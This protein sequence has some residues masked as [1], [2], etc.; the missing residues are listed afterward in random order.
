MVWHSWIETGSKIRLLVGNNRYNASD[1]HQRSLYSHLVHNFA[2]MCNH[3]SVLPV[4]KCKD[5]LYCPIKTLAKTFFTT[6]SPVAM[7][8]FCAVHH[9]AQYGQFTTKNYIN[10]HSY[11]FSFCSCAEKVF[12]VK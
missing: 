8:I 4:V 9:L 6:C 10:K 7:A 2:L 11:Y 12:F 3:Q 5:G 1:L